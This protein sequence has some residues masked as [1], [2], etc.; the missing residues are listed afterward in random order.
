[1]EYRGVQYAIVRTMAPNGWR[2]IIK[3]APNDKTGV[4]SNRDDAVRLAKKF[5][6]ELIK[7]RGRKGLDRAERHS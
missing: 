5:I 7:Y 1:M 4:V 2:W 3:R 6:D